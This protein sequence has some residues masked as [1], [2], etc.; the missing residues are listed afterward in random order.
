[1]L[2]RLPFTRILA[3]VS[4]LVHPAIAAEQSSAGTGERVREK[5]LRMTEF[6]DTMLPGVLEENNVTLH[7][8]PKFSDLRDYEF[9]RFPFELRYGLTNRWEL[10]GGLS[11]FTP[12]PFN[13]GREHRWGPGEVKLAALRDLDCPLGFFDETTLGL[14][15]RIPLGTPPA[16]INDHYTHLKPSF[17]AARRLRGWPSTTLYTNLAYDRSIDLTHRDPGPA[18]V[19]RRDI[20]EAAPGLLYKP[21]EV[22]WFT[23]YRL[24]RIHD[25]AGNHLGHKFQA[26]TIWDVPLARTEKW[27][28]PGKWQVELAYRVELEEGRDR[29]HGISARV[30]WRTTLRE[31]LQHGRTPAKK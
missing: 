17:T 30:N 16:E 20:L 26:G 8:R 18:G 5:M 12:N 3:L 21:G 19:E 11:P 24:R 25:D 29:D 4:L 14:E 13:R 2:P 15:A 7:F 28:L 6:L 31:V 10:R 1:M 9:V 23:E 27:N 22:G